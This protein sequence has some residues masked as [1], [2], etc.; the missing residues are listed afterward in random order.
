M[1]GVD[2]KDDHLSDYER[3]ICYYALP[4]MV[5]PITLGII[6]AYAVCVCEAL[7]ALVYGVLSQN[8]VWVEWGAWALAGIMVLGIVVF[9]GRAFL[10]DLRQRRLLAA[11]RGV[12]DAMGDL[13]DMPDPFAGHLLLKHP[14]SARGVLLEC[15]A[16]EAVTRYTLEQT[17]GARSWDIT[18][19]DG[20]SVCR[21]VTVSGPPSF[22]L[23]VGI[24]RRLR[25]YRGE[26][27]IAEIVQRFSF[28]APQVEIRCQDPPGREYHIRGQSVFAGAGMVGRIYELRG[29]VY[30]DI[31]R[32]ALHDALLGFFATL[33]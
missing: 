13:R 29:S 5:N 21:V 31:R 12:P 4:R 28:S 16:G 9:M 26:A 1:T 6:V 8:P 33:G 3:A 2:A 27:P 25:V 11:A 19:T 15:H 18:A 22:M 17:P 14:R 23:S 7:A 10:N 32:E 20:T 24:P 30:L